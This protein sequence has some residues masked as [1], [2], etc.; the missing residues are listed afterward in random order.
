[1]L[2]I[3]TKT[4]KTYLSEKG[5]I[6]ADHDKATE[7]FKASF[8]DGRNVEID[9]VTSVTRRRISKTTYRRND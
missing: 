4:G 6:R 2:T 1:M 3:R 9:N 5:M 8:D 7:T